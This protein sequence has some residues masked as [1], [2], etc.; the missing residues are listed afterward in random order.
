MPI[1][2]IGELSRRADVNIG[3][4]RYYERI[5]LLAVPPRTGGDHRL[6]PNQLVFN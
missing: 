5:G 1:S 2:S 6:Y 3:T 4:I